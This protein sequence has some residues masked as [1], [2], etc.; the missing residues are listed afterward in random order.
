MTT[1]DGPLPP[2]RIVSEQ[3]GRIVVAVTNPD[4]TESL[5]TVASQSTHPDDIREM[6]RLTLATRAATQ[7]QL[8]EFS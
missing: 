2:Y 1:L 8:R 7:D 4:L 6:I 5:V 3:A